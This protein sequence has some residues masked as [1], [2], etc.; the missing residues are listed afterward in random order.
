MASKPLPTAPPS[1]YTIEDCDGSGTGEKIV[2]YAESGWGKSTLCMMAPKPVF[3]CLDDGIRK[4]R[5]PVTGKP[6]R[7]IPGVKTFADVLEVLSPVNYPLFKDDES[8]ILDTATRTQALAIL[9]M[10]VNIKHEKGHPVERLD[11]YGFGK[12]YG[13]LVDTMNLLLRALDQLQMT[14]KNII[15][16][17]QE[18]VSLKVNPMGED[19]MQFG[20]DLLHTTSKNPKSVR[21]P[22][23]AWAD[24]VCR[25]GPHEVIASEIQDKPVDKGYQKGFRFGKVVENVTRVVHLK[26][27]SLAMKVKSRTVDEPC[28]PFSEPKDNGLWVCIFGQDWNL[29]P[30]SKGKGKKK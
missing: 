25:I 2:L 9:W 19:Y 21:D 8:I 20:P 5:H 11:G 29:E 1:K 6:A 14:G 7:Y 17:A 4:L 23:C 16:V 13:H 26:T 22:F 30:A 3:I 15:V 12:G 24:H 18:G 28:A 10:F 27:E